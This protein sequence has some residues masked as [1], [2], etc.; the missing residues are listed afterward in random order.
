[1]GYGS[2]AAS[3]VISENS[4]NVNLAAG[5]DTGMGLW[6]CAGCEAKGIHPSSGTIVEFES[7]LLMAS[8]YWQHAAADKLKRKAL[9]NI[10]EA[11]RPLAEGD[12]EEPEWEPIEGDLENW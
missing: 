3:G 2:T 10:V 7:R 12:T 8:P 1:M 4:F 11:L 5:D 6:R 9:H